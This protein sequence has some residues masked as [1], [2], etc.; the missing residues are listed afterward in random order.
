[1]LRWDK[2]KEVWMSSGTSEKDGRPQQDSAVASYIFIEKVCIRGPGC[3][4]RYDSDMMT[5]GLPGPPTKADRLILVARRPSEA[6]Y[7]DRHI[8][9]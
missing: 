7:E 3:R 5:E 1:M 8:Q 6:R 4:Q 2:A 9:R